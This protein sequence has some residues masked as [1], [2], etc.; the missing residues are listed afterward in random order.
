MSFLIPQT[1]AFS[2]PD[3]GLH[4]PHFQWSHLS[5]FKAYDHKSLRRGFQV[6]SQVCSACHSMNLVSFRSLVGV[7]HSSDEVKAMA[8]EY[9]Y[10]DGPNDK[11]D[12]FMRS[13]KPSD[14]LP[15]PYPNDEA[16]RV[17]N[18]GALPPDLSCIAR[19]RHGEE[20]YI[21]ALLT[22]YHEPPGLFFFNFSWCFYSRRSTLQSL[23]SRWCHRNDA[24]YLR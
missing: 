7:T 12:Y 17:A 1:L 15:R 22:G 6:Y 3:V 23:L 24:S 11:G 18:N 4:A 13:G 14:P 5:L 8:Q 2:T 20:N 19:A 16:A 21:L 10:K 9:Q